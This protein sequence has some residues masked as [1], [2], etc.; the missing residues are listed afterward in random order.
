MAAIR[1]RKDGSFIFAR[2]DMRRGEHRSGLRRDVRHH[3]IGEEAEEA[4]LV[5]ADLMDVDV[6]KA[7][8]CQ[9]LDLRQVRRGVGPHTTPLATSSG[10]TSAAACSKCRG[11]G[12]SCCMSPWIPA[13]GQISWAVLRASASDSAQQQ[14]YNRSAAFRR[15]PR[16][17]TLRRASR[18]PRSRSVRRQPGRPARLT[19]RSP[20]RPSARSAPPATC[21]AGRR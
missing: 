12:S 1:H 3:L 14:A 8:V 2:D 16:R 19:S 21:R 17:R 10:V 7:S 5:V 20:P 15:L 9:L 6:G 4:L 11:S 13:I 18:R